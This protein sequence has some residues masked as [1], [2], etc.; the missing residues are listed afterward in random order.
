[1][2]PIPDY[3]SPRKVKIPSPLL[4]I[5]VSSNSSEAAGRGVETD[6]RETASNNAGIP[7][8]DPYSHEWKAGRIHRT[9]SL[10]KN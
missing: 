7:Q 9:G 3:N 8:L 2:E 10:R 4:L 5:P 6:K 1:M